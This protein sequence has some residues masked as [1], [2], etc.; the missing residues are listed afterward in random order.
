MLRTFCLVVIGITFLTGCIPER[1]AW[2]QKLTVV[3]DTP[4][5]QVSGSSVVRVEAVFWGQL[6]ATGTEVEYDIRGE[7]TVVEV[8]PGQYLFVL[9]GGSQERFKAFAGDRFAGMT[10]QEWLREIPRQ[11]EPVSIP[12]QDAPMMVTFG[13]ITDP[14]S[15]VEVNP[16]D[17][18]A[19][20]G[21]GISLDAVFLE[22]VSESD[23]RQ[24]ISQLL[25]PPFF[26]KWTILDREALEQGGIRNPYFRSLIGDLS[27]SDFIRN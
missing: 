7:A 12:P 22:I 23:F 16:T 27:P 17:L 3:V 1:H 15:V 24:S 6:P 2:H 11:T 21:I 20:F 10:R 13:D 25:L 14:A 18:A 19:S 9:L 5:G 26:E 8:A 4:T